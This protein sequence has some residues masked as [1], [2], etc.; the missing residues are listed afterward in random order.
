[1]LAEPKLAN[2]PLS[3]ALRKYAPLFCGDNVVDPSSPRAP[4]SATTPD[5]ASRYSSRTSMTSHPRPGWRLQ[6]IVVFLPSAIDG[7]DTLSEAVDGPAHRLP[8]GSTGTA[9]AGVTTVTATIRPATCDPARARAHL[10]LPLPR[11]KRIYIHLPRS[12]L[13]R[14]T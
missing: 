9:P 8:P 14:A 13:R 2:L 5:V 1:V 11:N 6:L 10:P 4:V 3:R 12:R 7:S